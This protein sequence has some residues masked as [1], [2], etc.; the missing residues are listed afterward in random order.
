MT[1]KTRFDRIFDNHLMLRDLTLLSFTTIFY[2]FS[3][4][5][6]LSYTTGDSIQTESVLAIA[7][8]SGII[9]ST[10]FWSMMEYSA[11]RKEESMFRYFLGGDTLEKE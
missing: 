5:A 3:L 11:R 9:F 10:L 8:G 6:I 4:A 1:E 2:G 7:F